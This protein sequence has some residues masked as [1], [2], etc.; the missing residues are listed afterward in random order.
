MTRDGA[1]RAP[2]ASAKARHS[3]RCILR[4]VRAL[5]NRKGK[6]CPDV[7][8][9]ESFELGSQGRLAAGRKPAPPE[10]PR[11]VRQNKHSPEPAERRPIAL[12]EDK[13][14][15]TIQVPPSP[16]DALKR[17]SWFGSIFFRR[18]RFFVRP[19]RK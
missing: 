5:N 17:S 7:C 15:P 16:S 10:P 3:Y 4:T 11:G 13:Y 18:P 2:K 8:V 19:D 1:Q 12:A 9:R 14:K 6:P